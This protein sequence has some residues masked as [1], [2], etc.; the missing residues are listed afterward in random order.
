MTRREARPRKS[1]VFLFSFL[2]EPKTPFIH[3]NSSSD[4]LTGHS[5]AIEP[6]ELTDALSKKEVDETAADWETDEDAEGI[7][8]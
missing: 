1:L 7:S 2:L 8:L 4:E 3:Y 5:A 6:I